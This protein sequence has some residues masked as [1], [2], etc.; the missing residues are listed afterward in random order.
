MAKKETTPLKPVVEDVEVP[1][2][3]GKDECIDC[4]F[5][6]PAKVEAPVITTADAVGTYTAQ[7]GDTY[8]SIASMFKATGESKHEF[9]T[10]LFI[11]NNGKA[12]SAGTVIKL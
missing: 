6:E 3:C 10:R 9:A 8:A 4:P 1:P 5:D 12:V 7:N 2:C 11:L